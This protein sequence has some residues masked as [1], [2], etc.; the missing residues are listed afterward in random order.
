LFYGGEESVATAGEGLDEA[1]V[2]GG[3]TEGFAD[4][5]DGGVEPVLVVDEG[6][7]GP[8]GAADFL[9][10]EQ[11]AG[12]VEEQEEY[13]EGLGVELDADSLAAELAGDAVCLK[14]S[15]AIAAR[16]EGVR[17]GWLKCTG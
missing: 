4:A 12:A 17:H 2:A 8:E 16:W 10:C 11:S 6:T 7:V 3:V 15:E 9:A 13:L 5:V 1:G 14:S